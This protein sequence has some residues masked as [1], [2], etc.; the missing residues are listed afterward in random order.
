MIKHCLIFFQNGKLYEPSER[1]LEA[2]APK[3][4]VTESLLI[5]LRYSTIRNIIHFNIIF[6]CPLSEVTDIEGLIEKI[7][8]FVNSITPDR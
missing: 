8:E 1:E 3:K 7:E 5:L 4:L 2:M 6:R